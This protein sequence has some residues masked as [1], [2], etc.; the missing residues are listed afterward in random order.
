MRESVDRAY[1]PLRIRHA[2]DVS[3]ASDLM[4]L[5][6]RLG[7]WLGI[8]RRPVPPVIISDA[9]DALAIS[10]FV[11]AGPAE[12]LTIGDEIVAQVSMVE[13]TR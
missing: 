9:S 7:R 2:V 8:R 12:C 6:E 11:D 5:P 4:V 3:R 10:Q 1:I 13:T